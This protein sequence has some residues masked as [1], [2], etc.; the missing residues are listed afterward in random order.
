MALDSP[1]PTFI[2]LLACLPYPVGPPSACHHLF[3][4]IGKLVLVD[5]PE[6]PKVVRRKKSR[7][8][9]GSVGGSVKG[10]VRGA[11][12]SPSPTGSVGSSAARKGPRQ[13]LKPAPVEP[14]RQVGDHAAFQC[15]PPSL[16]ACFAFAG[17]QTCLPSLASL[18]YHL[19]AAVSFTVCRLP[20]G[21]PLFLPATSH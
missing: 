15:F 11:S 5:A 20:R 21:V 10:S 4:Y 9:T 17:T 3:S 2:S 12:R 16:P 1:P 19:S 18:A 14:K 7:S 6:G 8:P 13:P